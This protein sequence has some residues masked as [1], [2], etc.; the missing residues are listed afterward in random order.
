MTNRESESC[1]GVFGRADDAGSSGRIANCKVPLIGVTER[2]QTFPLARNEVNDNEFTGPVYSHDKNPVR[3]PA[4]TG[5]NVRRH[6]TPTTTTLTSIRATQDSS[7]AV[8]DERL[9]RVGSEV[10]VVEQHR[11]AQ[12]PRE[13]TETIRA[14][15]AAAS[16]S[17]RRSANAKCPRWLT[18]NCISSRC[19][20]APGGGNAITP[21]LLTSKCNGTALV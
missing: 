8:F 11:R 13:L 15:L 7:T 12:V 5:H 3:Q 1:R 2:G 17:R 20:S 18:A 6:R 14:L 19:W 9:V 4:N 10:Q 21:A 16:A